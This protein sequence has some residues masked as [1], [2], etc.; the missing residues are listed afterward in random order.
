MTEQH[1]NQIQVPPAQEPSKKIPDKSLSIVKPPLLASIAAGTALVFAAI[2][3]SCLARVPL[4][5][6]AVGILLD[7]DRVSY[8]KALTEGTIIYNFNRAGNITVPDFQEDITDF[9]K[10]PN[11]SS[12]DSVIKVARAI[13]NY[14]N[15]PEVDNL[16][17]PKQGVMIKQFDI[18]AQILDAGAR[19]RLLTGA[20]SAKSQENSY[21][22][23][24]NILNSENQLSKDELIGQ[25][26]LLDEMK[27]LGTKGYVSYPTV[28]KQLSEVDSLKSKILENNSKIADIRTKIVSLRQKQREAL[29]EYIQKYVLYA[30]SDIYVQYQDFA[31]FE[32]V[33][34]GDNVLVY[35]TAPL[36]LPTSIPIFLSSKSAN[37]TSV[38][39]SLLATPL[40]FEK[41]R[42]GGI[43]GNILKISS[44]PTTIDAVSQL[45]GLSEIGK[46]I[47]S[48]AGPTP[49]MARVQLIR[50]ENAT[51]NQGNYLWSSKSDPPA[52]V[53]TSDQLFVDITTL[54]VP[55]I[56]LVLPALRSF[57]GI[58]YN[59]YDTI[60]KQEKHKST[61]APNNQ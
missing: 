46:S 6:E 4:K 3:W 13:N 18:Y 37:L 12:I 31:Q 35:S 61:E 17:S 41:S 14:I 8:S 54:E 15:D 2:I 16:V 30:S 57:F 42:Y 21:L 43:R 48:T 44:V 32:P 33:R 5:T 50:S 11:A 38:G 1:P 28:L 36:Q 25:S 20:L 47:E 23:E 40:G 59:T 9:V 58:S 19:E 22:Y 53:R 24:I 60:E 51:P 7:L 10:D 34:E 55:P 29:S 26:K 52:A 56:V 27:Q 45:T 39:N 49:Y